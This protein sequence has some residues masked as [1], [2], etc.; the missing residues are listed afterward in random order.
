MV[1]YVTS[2]W[3]RPLTRWLWMFVVQWVSYT[4][5]LYP[6]WAKSNN[7]QLCYSHLNNT[8]AV[9]NLGFVE[10]LIKFTS[11]WAPIMYWHVKFDDSTNGQD[12]VFGAYSQSWTSHLNQI[13]QSLPLPMH[14]LCFIYVAVFRSYSALKLTGFKKLRPNLH[15]LPL[16]KIRGKTGKIPKWMLQGH[17]RTR[18]LIYFWCED[19]ARVGRFN[20]FSQFLS[21]SQSRG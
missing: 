21:N 9:C 10:K 20:T 5:T 7:P 15:F 12:P 8:G 18:P 3:P 17:P 14:L 6:M 16:A 1:C 13:C 4:E 19:T 11:F 2:R